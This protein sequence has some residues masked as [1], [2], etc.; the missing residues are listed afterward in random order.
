MIHR[1]LL[2]TLFFALSGV[3][4]SNDRLAPQT[5]FPLPFESFWSEP[6]VKNLSHDIQTNGLRNFVDTGEDLKS[7]GGRLK[8]F[9]HKEG[10]RVI[11]KPISEEN[12]VYLEKLLDLQQNGALTQDGFVP[13]FLIPGDKRHYYELD[14][15]AYDSAP[16]A[17]QRGYVIADELEDDPVKYSQVN[18]K[19]VYQ[20]VRFLILQLNQ[21]RLNHGHA[22]GQNILVHPETGKV[23]LIDWKQLG[24][25]YYDYS[26]FHPDQIRNSTWARSLEWI[27]LTG[28]DFS[29]GY[30]S[31]VVRI[32]RLYMNLELWGASFQRAILIN[33]DF[34]GTSLRHA[35]FTEAILRGAKLMATTLW[36]ADFSGADLRGANLSQANFLNT[37]LRDADMRGTDL[38]KTNLQE[39][40]MQGI[41]LDRNTKLYKTT[42]SPKDL[43]FFA[44]ETGALFYFDGKKEAWMAANAA[45]LEDASPE[46]GRQYRPYEFYFEQPGTSYLTGMAA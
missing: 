1:I 10:L 7:T 2:S 31:Y 12:L 3:V 5:R 18:L 8:V 26:N 13:T 36:N 38:R 22:H 20:N 46:E 37:I 17:S 21:A 15:R 14:L 4:W 32:K 11:Q 9:Q 27:D 16:L 42:I 39:I 23:V 33:S 40:D 35:D 41:R 45:G 28:K 30:F 29:E 34:T 44:R 6:H 43:E 24:G 19:T 25:T